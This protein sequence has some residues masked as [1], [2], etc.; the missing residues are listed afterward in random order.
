MT[1]FH[2]LF[3]QSRQPANFTEIVFWWGERRL[4]FNIII[5]VT[6]LLSILI[7]WIAGFTMDWV[8]TGILAGTY[9][10]AANIIYTSGWLAEYILR[11]SNNFD[12]HIHFLGP[13]FFAMGLAVGILITFF[14]GLLAGYVGWFD[15]N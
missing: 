13:I 9:L 1:F 14:G 3:K 2:N 15:Y 11:K 6:G 10:I 7:C 12:E 5:G 8:F 4:A